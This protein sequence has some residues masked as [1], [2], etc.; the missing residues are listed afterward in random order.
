MR[1]T[2][3]KPCR[4]DRLIQ[5]AAY[6]LS[7]VVIILMLYPFL[8][9]LAVSLS[10]SEYVI[11]GMVKILPKGF[12][13]NAYKAAL[14]DPMIGTGYL[15]TILYATSGTLLTLVLT[16]L[17]AYPLTVKNFR[18]K[19]IFVV[20]LTITMYFSGGLIPYYIL[21]QNLHLKNTIWALILP[22]VSVWY[23]IICR[24]FFQS[25]IPIGLR[26]SALIDGAS[27]LRILF[28]IYL[29][30]AK[31]IIATISLW[32]IVGHWNSWFNAMLFIEDQNKYPL[33]MVVRKVLITFQPTSKMRSIIA[34]FKPSG[35]SEQTVRCA[36]IIVTILPIIMIYPFLQ[37]Y[38]VKGIMVGSIK[39]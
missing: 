8:Y 35:V 36:I 20:F 39:G 16:L 3:I 29:P 13:I 19:S 2:A 28:G 38:F 27:D 21:V 7:F 26:E 18:G 5:W 24:T 32:S 34:S 30:L 25:T 15:N 12:N 11:M 10:R 6:A 9:V 1:K 22:G 4:T 14:A 33:Q 37:K 17:T 31:P 23:I